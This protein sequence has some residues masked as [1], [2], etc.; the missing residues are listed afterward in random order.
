MASYYDDGVNSQAL[1]CNLSNCLTCTS[2]TSCLSCSAGQ[3][4][5]TNNSC[6][7]CMSSC[8]NCSSASN[9]L[10]CV[11]DFIFINGTCVVDCSIINFC[12]VCSKV[13]SSVICSS[14]KNRYS[15]VN[16]SCIYQCANGSLASNEQ[17]NPNFTCTANSSGGTVCSLNSLVINLVAINKQT[18]GNAMSMI[19][20]IS[21]SNLD[22]FNSINW[23]SVVQQ[24]SSLKFKFT[25]P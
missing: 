14:C 9:C 1:P 7:D 17:C 3:Y 15:L 5:A 19:Y 24:S 23:S 11:I 25:K 21:P 20:S 6:V 18:D 10:N 2:A 12:H 8:L 22:A 4:L 16:N 13:L